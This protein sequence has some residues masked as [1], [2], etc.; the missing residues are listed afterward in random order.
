MATDGSIPQDPLKTLRLQ[1][2]WNHLP[3]LTPE[4]LAAQILSATPTLPATPGIR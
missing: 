1:G 3:S 2:S 4:F